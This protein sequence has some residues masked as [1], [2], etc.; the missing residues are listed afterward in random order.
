[1]INQ[2]DV[3]RSGRM[4]RGLGLSLGVMLVSLLVG[5]AGVGAW[6]GWYGS[7]SVGGVGTT[8][9]ASIGVQTAPTTTG[10]GGEIVISWP[11]ASV[12]SGTVK[13]YTVNRYSGAVAQTITGACAGP[14]ANTG[15]VEI[16]VPA[17]TWTYTATPI[18]TG[19]NWVGGESA[20]SI[21]VTT[22][23]VAGSN[24]LWFWVAP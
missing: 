13:T 17:G 22:T 10:T 23:G 24:N 2:G 1:M 16:N 19:T 21:A 20:K 7:F 12:G 4:R 9:A 8:S 18:L 15:C 14:V 3:S 5:S 11:A 6:A